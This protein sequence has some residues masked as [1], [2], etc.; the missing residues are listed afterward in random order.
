[1]S[2]KPEN[3]TDIVLVMCP[4]WGVIQPPVGLSYLS[5]FL[6][7]RGFSVKCLDL[8]LA[9]Y[10]VFPEK[11]YWELNYPE[12]FLTLGLFDEFILPFLNP[13]IP[14]WVD[15]ILRPG[16]RAVGFSLFMSNTIV[17]SLLARQIKKV[18]PQ[19]TIIAGGPEVTR[20]KRVMHDGVHRFAHMEQ[21][22]V[23][24]GVFDVLVDGEGEEA[25]LDLL[26]LLKDKKDFR[27]LPGILYLEDHTLKATPSRPLMTDLDVLPPADYHDFDLPAYIK[28]SLPL[29]TSRG[30]INRCTFCADS[31]L[32]KTYRA[33]SARKTVEEIKYLAREYGRDEFEI[34]D[35][36][37][38]GD[39]KRIEAIC[40]LIMEAKLQI[41]WSAKVSARKE[42]TFDLLK[43]MRDAGCTSLAYGIESGSPRVLK[44]MRKNPD[45]ESAQ[46]V[47]QDTSRAGILAN[48]FFIIGYP[49]ET[50]EDF[51]MTLDFIERN[52]RHI[53]RFDQITGCHLEE[54]SFLG[55]N[56]DAYG[57]VFKDDGW[58]SAVSTPQ[59]RRE[60][61][62]RFREFA[63]KLHKH[64]QCEV[65]G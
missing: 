4:G 17:S 18:S 5:G 24:E 45:L 19:T 11:K 31:P 37:F 14:D 32:W 36:I 9:L 42:M 61:L 49:T 58:H 13:I 47:I 48:C 65:Q 38:N 8:S 55:L 40:D 39:I 26:P 34:A 44:D 7:S 59:I 25:L 22:T 35:S 53:Y 15:A 3:G 1:M 62:A 43:K 27:G 28:R 50:E 12:Y 2:A 57:I 33:R 56:M 63:R 29:V 23:M 54:D 20:I 16:P 41:R 46:R 64:Y 21:D 6:R 60:R 51:Q 30:C 10:K 52:A